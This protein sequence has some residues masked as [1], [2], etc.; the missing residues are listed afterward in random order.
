MLLGPGAELLEVEQRQVEISRAVT[1][2]WERGG[3]GA[4]SEGWEGRTGG[5]LG[6]KKRAEC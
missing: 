4:G 1:G 3:K 5:G 6:G 2:P